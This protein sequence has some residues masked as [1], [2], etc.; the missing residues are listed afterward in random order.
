MRRPLLSAALA[1]IALP[2]LAVPAHAVTPGRFFP[3]EQ[4]DTG[5]ERVGDVDVARDGTGGVVYVKQD[6]GA[7][8]IFLA[9][10][11]G[12]SF[13]A[14]ERVD[15]GLAAA[16]SKPVIA[17]SDGGRLAVAFESA[18]AVLA[19]VK[20]AGDQPWTGTQVLAGAGSDPAV[21]LS[22]NGV[23]YASF[24]VPG[25]GG[26]DVRAA[27]LDRKAAG[28]NPI[29]ASLDVDPARGAGAGTG[30]SRVSV[31]ADGSALV[32]WGEGRGA[33]A[34][35][36]F[37][38][39][40][41]SAPQ[42]LA[43]SGDAVDV[44]LEDDSSFGWAVFRSGSSVLARRLLGSTFDPA[45]DLG[46]AEPAGIPRL[47]VSGRGDGFAA[48]GGTATNGAYGAVLKDDKFNAG[49]V[50]GGGFGSPPFPAPVVA[51]SADG[52][53]AYQ[54]G[55]EDGSRSIRARPYDTDP[56]SR[57]VTP[58]GPEVV[59][60]DPALGT[61]DAARGLVAGAD[62]AGDLVIAFPQGDGLDRKLAAATFDRA[63][64]SFRGTTTTR[65]RSAT[66]PLSWS[67]AFELWGGVTYT[68]FLDGRQVAQVADA[69]KAAL[70]APPPDGA[71]RWW[72]VATDRRGQA[73]RTPT[74]TLRIDGTPP[75]LN[76]S[77]KRRGRV[78]SVVA[79]ASDASPTGRTTAGM[80]SVVIDWGDGSKKLTASRGS[81]RYGGGRP[82]T[83]KV[84][85]LDKAGNAAVHQRPVARG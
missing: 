72:V 12:G 27:R 21:D 70:P 45:V 35:R 83:L 28:F 40:P 68:V 9:R 8:H 56:R 73:T 65:Y 82:V 71:H 59:L 30:R 57:V 1:A 85:A 49:P 63:P 52:A 19:A 25:D 48:F 54:Q 67:Q 76:V 36:I 4:L 43:E 11:A 33:F 14:P 22:I 6:G 38:Y 13:Q 41:S 53:I 51:Y 10:F 37:E 39:R 81:H 77:V 64:G 31:A 84:T 42:Q 50:I 20:P 79:K 24:T 29:D 62:R 60:S 55:A 5:I 46:S 2:A 34:R 47:A 78:V 15:G 44:A 61:P 18:G 75:R 32:G 16:S 17:A 74:R 58:P 26:A 80:K 7:D 69:T 23:G 3:G 66:A